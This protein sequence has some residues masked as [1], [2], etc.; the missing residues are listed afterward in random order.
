[1]IMN[2]TEYELKA[3]IKRWKRAAI[4]LAS[5]TAATLEGMP[6]RISK[7][8]RAR[9]VSLCAKASFLLQGQGLPSHYHESDEAALL[10][11]IT[12]CKDA[13]ENHR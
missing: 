6:K 12:R 7:S 13:A 4:Y 2:E 3:E 9:Q 1:M 11:A 10:H 8:E 5:C